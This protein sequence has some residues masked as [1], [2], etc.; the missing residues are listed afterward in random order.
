MPNHVYG[1]IWILGADVE[2]DTIG[3]ETLQTT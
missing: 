3:I 1:V 2:N